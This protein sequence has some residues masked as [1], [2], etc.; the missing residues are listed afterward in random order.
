ME[1]TINIRRINRKRE[2]RNSTGFSKISEHW[3]FKVSSIVI[4]A[5]VLYFVLNSVRITVQKVDILKRAEREV[6]ELRLENLHLS[7]GI[8]EMSSDKYLEKEARDRLNFGG[9]DEVVFVIPDSTLEMA[10]EEVEKIIASSQESIYESGS[11]FEEWLSFVLE[12]V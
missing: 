8:E 3:L 11:N 9:K 7:V 4:F 2:S 5:L 1:K 12:G 6:Q 10:M